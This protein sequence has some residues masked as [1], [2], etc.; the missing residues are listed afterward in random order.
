FLLVMIATAIGC[1]RQLIDPANNQRAR[2]RPRPQPVPSAN[3]VPQ[4]FN[5]LENVPAESLLGPGPQL[6]STYHEVKPGETAISIARQYGLNVDGLL[7]AN[8]LSRSSVLQPKQMLF[9]PRA[10]K[11]K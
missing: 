7:D 2:I 4:D 1:G 8:G 5:Q 9:I 6:T 11:S 10:A 3:T